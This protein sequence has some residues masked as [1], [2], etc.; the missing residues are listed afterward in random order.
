MVRYAT[1]LICCFLLVACS[2]E[3][4]STITEPSGVATTAPRANATG[5]LL[6]TNISV[7]F[8]NAMDCSTID[9]STFLLA[10][11]AGCVSGTVTCSGQRATFDPAADLLENT[12]YTATIASTVRDTD[13]NALEA[14]HSWTFVTGMSFVPI[15]P[16]TF[17][18]GSPD[19]ETDRESDETQHPVT[20]STGFY[21]QPTEVTQGQW[22]DV[23]GS[24][25]ANFSDC[26]DCP[27][28]KVSWND[29]QVFIEIINQRGEGT[30]RLPTEAEWEYAARAETDTPF[31]TGN[32]LST[33]QANFNGRDNP[34]DGCTAGEHRGETLPVASFDSNAR[35]LYDMH[36]NVWE[37]CQDWYGAYPTGAV[38]DPQGPDS[39]TYR[40]LRGGSWGAWASNCRSAKRFFAS[41]P[42]YSNYAIGFRLVKTN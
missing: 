17:D 40:V 11:A 16:G 22:L 25:P 20:I 12:P 8:T 42:N 18:M 13:G 36:G 2:D 10:N 26:G 4:D 41:A 35:G 38:T 3:S 30:Y 29:V 27:V 31:N 39:G 14:V 6:D 15:P 7:T 32:C 23:M 9:A 28:E 24:N 1:I 37:W 19:D 33:D 34:Y 21:M 5:V